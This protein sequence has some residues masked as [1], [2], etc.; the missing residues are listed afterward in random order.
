MSKSLKF[1]FDPIPEDVINHEPYFQ[2]YELSKHPLLQ[3]ENTILETS[4]PEVVVNLAAG[5]YILGKVI[6][7]L[8]EEEQK[9]IIKKSQERRKVF[10]KVTALRNKAYGKKVNPGEFTESVFDKHRAQILELFGRFHSNPEVQDIMFKAHGLSVSCET[11]ASLR[12]TS[13]DAINE[14][15]EKFKR[16]YSDVRLGY[17]RSRLDELTYLY[18]HRKNIYQSTKTASDYTL[19][20]KT[21]EQIRKE[22]EGDVLNVSGNIIHDIE[23]TINNQ[24][25]KSMI[26]EALLFEII[27]ARIAAKQNK[28]PLFFL[29]KMRQSIYKKFNGTQSIDFNEK[30]I[31][32]STQMLGL[33]T[34]EEKAVVKIKEDNVLQ[35]M[36][37]EI[38]NNSADK[39]K[40]MLLERI[41][42]RK[43]EVD[44]ASLSIINE[45]EET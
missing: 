11:L 2:A 5:A 19:L 45:E 17:K 25:E 26:E 42:E 4:D 20:L 1:K 10:G 38:S 31:W 14:L 21:I 43:K 28:N 36:P 12:M 18:N 35:I 39:I 29:T 16:D 32:P 6:A 9:E 40:S 13:A 23:L 44:D 15:K 7:H 33:D 30:P 27:V 22:V 37:S 34:I 3:P 8:P 41:K 24:I